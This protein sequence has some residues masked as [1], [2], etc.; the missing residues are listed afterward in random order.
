[1][2]LMTRRRR[3]VALRRADGTTV[4]EHCL[5]ADTALA[6]M[7]GLLGRSELPAGEGIL[8]RPCNSIHMFFMR[9][10]I[11]AIFVDRD[12]TVLKIA[13]NLKPWR[14]AGARRA[15]AVIELAVGEGARRGIGPGDR[16]EQAE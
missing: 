8:I 10:G 3:Y 15:H 9:F 4:C 2:R 11:D 13:R 1:V 6:R 7:K 5:I 14:M 16:I 12:G